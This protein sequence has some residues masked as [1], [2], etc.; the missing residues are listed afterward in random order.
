MVDERKN[1]RFKLRDGDNFGVIPPADQIR[2]SYRNGV[3]EIEIPLR[4]LCPSENIFITPKSK[5]V[6]FRTYQ[7]NYVPA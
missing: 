1:L 2:G 5:R 6:Y 4:D 7:P 3:T